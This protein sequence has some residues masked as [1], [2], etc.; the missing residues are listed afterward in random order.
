MLEIKDHEN[1]I[2]Y[3]L[4]PVNHYGF[5]EVGNVLGYNENLEIEQFDNIDDW[6]GRLNELGIELNNI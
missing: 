5:V 1:K 2:W 3:I 4:T 6:L